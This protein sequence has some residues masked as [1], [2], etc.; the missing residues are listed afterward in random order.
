MFQICINSAVIQIHINSNPPP[1]PPPSLPSPVSGGFICIHREPR[2]QNWNCS[3]PQ[4]VILMSLVGRSFIVSCSSI[5]FRVCVPSITCLQKQQYKIK[6]TTKWVNCKHLWPYAS[7]KSQSQLNIQLVYSKNSC[8]MFTTLSHA[9]CRVQTFPI[10]I[11]LSCLHANVS[12]ISDLYSSGSFK[13][14]T[15]CHNR[16][17]LENDH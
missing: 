7:S 4:S 5:F 1:T 15:L 10:N 17:S 6:P 12:L 11:K 2:S 8:N 3:T 16:F 14:E 9:R 13:P